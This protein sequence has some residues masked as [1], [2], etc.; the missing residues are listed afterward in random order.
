M[1][2]SRYAERSATV[3]SGLAEGETVV[4]AGVHTV[5]E[6]ERVVAVKPLFT[7]D[8]TASA[9]APASAP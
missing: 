8:D 7:D 1:T 5:Y 2:I 4:L 3:G 9:A 6:G